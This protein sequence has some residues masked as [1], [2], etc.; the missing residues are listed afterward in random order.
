MRGGSDE[1]L[2]AKARDLAERARFVTPP[3][4]WVGSVIVRDGEIIG[5]GATGPYPGG[6]H[7]EAAAVRDAGARA[8]GATAY[9]TLE[10]CNHHGNTPPCTDAL[11]EAGVSR[12]VVAL[13]D[14]DPRVRG[15]GVGRLRDA[16]IDVELGVDA[17]AVEQSLAPYLHQRASGR[18]F[19]LLK[20]AMSLDGRTA[21]ADGSSQWIT[22]VEARADAHRLRAESQAVVV[23]PGTARA[24]RPRLTVRGLDDLSERQPV[25]VLLDARGRVPADGPLFDV[26]LAPTLVV[27]TELAPAGVVDEWQSAG[28]K[29]EIVGPGRHDRGVDLAA[30]LTLLA[31]RYDV[32]QA[33]IEGGGRLH[34]AF[35]DEHLADRLVAYV[36]PVLLGER[37]L[38]VVGFP[39]PDSL[40]DASRWR[41]R[42]VT[43]L[44][45]DVRLT[46]DPPARE[47]EAA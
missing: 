34:G 14:P 22:G 36:A 32:L 10:P 37:G 30:V 28:A 4:P 38:P 39:G 19:A 6:L 40:A 23:G 47:R 2:M 25:R 3:N 42:D 21:A 7:A 17:D 33:M 24:D 12:V 9:V 35:V 41:L 16:G 26:E 20:T 1:E 46:L 45:A 31:E 29:V 43:R 18:A 13:E 15:T 8:R 11:I 5:H 27:T 44:G